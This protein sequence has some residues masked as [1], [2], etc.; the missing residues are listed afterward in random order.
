MKWSHSLKHANGNSFPIQQLAKIWN[1]ALG[2]GGSYNLKVR[3][4]IHSK[5]LN[6]SILLQAQDAPK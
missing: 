3:E 5:L 1:S 4:K 6:S 2:C